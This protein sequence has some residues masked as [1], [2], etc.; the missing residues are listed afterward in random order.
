MFNTLII[1]SIVGLSIFALIHST[2][3]EQRKLIWNKGLSVFIVNYEQIFHILTKL[4]YKSQDSD[5][6]SKVSSD[7][8]SSQ[9]H[10]IKRNIQQ[11]NDL[12][13]I[14]NVERFGPL[15]NDSV[16]I[17]VQV[18]NRI[19]YLQHTISSLAQA[20]DISKTLLIFSHDYYDDNINNLIRKID[21]CKVLQ[22]L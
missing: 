12:Q 6:N 14:L 22:V 13:P 20:K 5:Q 18:H 7:L 16:V 19:D 3:I 1:C 11:Y 9:L 2:P 4:A 17:V 21:F 10:E 15:K 8:R